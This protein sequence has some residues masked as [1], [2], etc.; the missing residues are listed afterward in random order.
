MTCQNISPKTGKTCAVDHVWHSGPH[1]AG[2]YVT[3]D[4]EYWEHTHCPERES[5]GYEDGIECHKPPGHD[6]GVHYDDYAEIYWR[7]RTD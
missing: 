4:H 5:L 1:R 3:H 2:S 7:R 6:D